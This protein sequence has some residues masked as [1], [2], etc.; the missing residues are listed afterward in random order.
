MWSRLY[1]LAVGGP[2]AAGLLVMGADPGPLA[3]ARNG[4]FDLYQRAAPRAY[5]PDLPVRVVDVDE[6][7]LAR[8]GQWPWPR[9]TVARLVDKLAA[10][11]A[12]IGRASCRERV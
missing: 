3:D 4:L 6:A 10:S 1:W 11:G 7:S 5:D 12:E 2:L 8:I 9:A